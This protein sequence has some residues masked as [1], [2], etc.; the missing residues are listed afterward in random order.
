MEQHVD[1]TRI[2]QADEIRKCIAHLRD[3]K[4]RSEAG[5]VNLAIFRLSCCCGLRRLEIAGLQM[6]DF[7]I[8]GPRPYILVREDNTK[9]EDG[10]RRKR[11]VPLW[12]DSGTLADLAEWYQARKA[13]GA[14]GRD[15]FL[16]SVRRGFVGQ[17]LTKEKVAARWMTVMR[18]ALGPIRAEQLAVHSG[19]RSFCSHALAAGRSPVEVRDAAGHRSISTTN[20]YL[21]ALE[22]ENVRDV[23][24]F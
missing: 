17:K 23:F 19:R 8:G 20:I 10:K 18:Q 4:A 11:K 7:V 13:M 15:P 24:S 5:A 14:T 2:L 22:S 16:C 6:R 9:G 3:K 1:R 12:W 21:Y